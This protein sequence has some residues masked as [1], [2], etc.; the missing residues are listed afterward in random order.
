MRLKQGLYFF[1]LFLSLAIF[2][3]AVK[4]P[5]HVSETEQ[6]LTKH[7]ICAKKIVKNETGHY[8]VFRKKYRTKGIEVVVPQLVGSP[9]NSEFTFREFS[10]HYPG[11]LF[12]SPKY[13]S[14]LQRGP[15]KA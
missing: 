3:N 6:D 1:F 11:E 7:A 5:L 12:I 13:S 8:L 4:S 14:H 10:V 9:Q 15:P 2:S